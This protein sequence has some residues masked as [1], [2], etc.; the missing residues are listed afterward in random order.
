MLLNIWKFTK[1]NYLSGVIKHG[2]DQSWSKEKEEKCKTNNNISFTKTRQWERER[3][4]EWIYR[5]LWERGNQVEWTQA[6]QHQ[7]PNKQP[8]CICKTITS[9]ANSF[10]ENE[11]IKKK[12]DCI[13]DIKQWP[14]EKNFNKITGERALPTVFRTTDQSYRP[15]QRAAGNGTRCIRPILWYDKWFLFWFRHFA[16]TRAALFLY[17]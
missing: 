2:A 6:G 16:A 10:R 5:Q 15:L 13:V 8:S 4:L 12:K 14:L 1:Q 9:S 7:C 11:W 3:Y 17:E